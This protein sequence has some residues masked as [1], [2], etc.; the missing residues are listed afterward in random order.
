MF[1]RQTKTSSSKTGEPYTTF[2]LVTT[3]RIGGKVRQKTLL[4]LG[5]NF[6]LA[7]ELWPQLCS[8]IEEILYRQQS[9]VAVSGVVEELAQRYAALLLTRSA[10]PQEAESADYREVDISSLELVRP[11]SVGV[12]HVA[13]SALNSLGLPEIFST[14][15]FNGGQ[16]AAAISSVV[17]RMAE[18]GSE[19]A[20]WH[21]LAQRSAL[22]E[23]LDVD[24]EAMPLIRLYRSSDLLVRH[25]AAIESALFNRINELFFL[26]ATVTLYDLTN[27][28]FEG[29]V[30]ANAKARRG[31]SKEKRSDCPLVTLGLILDGSGFIRRSRMFEGSVAEATTLASMLQGLSAPANALVIMDRGIATQANIDWLIEHHYRYLVVSRERT[32]HFDEGQSVAVSSASGQPLRIQRVLSDDG[33]EVRLYCHSAERQLK[34]NGITARFSKR[35]EDGLARIAASI[36]K[37][38]GEKRRDKVLQKIGRVQERSHGL[39]QHYRVDLTCDATG[40]LVTGLTWQQQPVDGTQLTHPGVYC[41]RSNELSWDEETL[42]RTYTMLTDLEAVFRSLKSELGLRPIYHHKE[43]RTEGHLFITVL[44]YQAVQVLRRRL[45]QHGINDSWASLRKIFATQYRITATFKQ[46]DG[47]TLHVRKATT[48]E[49][50]LARLYELLGL[51]PAPGG[52]RKTVQ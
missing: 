47:R 48:A 15:G 26:P 43:E 6:S 3:E 32:R 46:K 10:V 39:A 9:L 24:Y 27:T 31:H 2:R 33:Q 52:I 29:A 51:S 37:P 11:R 23:L 8:R 30:A 18:P 17:A 7:Q 1:I 50:K 20:G 13:M 19:L 35:F 44:A 25:R 21:W 28:F 42:W 34:E 5:R 41:L 49:P 4:N 36:A 38:R 22:G 16:Q 14:L 45:K 12:E 40:T